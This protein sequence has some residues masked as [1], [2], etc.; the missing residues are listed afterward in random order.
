MI[1]VDDKIDVF[2]KIVLDRLEEAYSEKIS[3][4]DGEAYEAV[5]A[6]EEKLKEKSRRF[7][8]G[9]EEDA[10][11]EAR[12]RT[13]KVVSG[14]RTQTLRL[15]HELVLEL[16]A[17]LR[18]RVTAYRTAESYLDYLRNRIASAAKTLR[19]FQGIQIEILEEDLVRYRSALK[20]EMENIG[21]DE[22]FFEW[23]PV[24]KGLM[25]GLIFYNNNRTIKL[26]GSFDVLLEDAEVIVGELVSTMLEERGESND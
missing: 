24:K 6:Y 9:H 17:A 19:E 20:L 14:V 22:E 26:D 8:E 7:I 5:K 16:C 13:S 25:G 21:L 11:S 1:T 18:E 23:L 12:K 3:E 2:T 15:R 10:R 4:L